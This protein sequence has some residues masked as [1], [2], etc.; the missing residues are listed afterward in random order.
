MVS[1]EDPPVSPVPTPK[2]KPVISSEEI[3]TATSSVE[4]I[5][6]SSPPLEEPPSIPLDQVSSDIPSIGAHLYKNEQSPSTFVPQPPTLEEDTPQAVLP[7]ESPPSPSSP[8]LDPEAFA[9]VKAPAPDV[10]QASPSEVAGDAVAQAHPDPPASP[11]TTSTEVPRMKTEDPEPYSVQPPSG[12]PS[13]EIGDSLLT[14]A[15]L[16]APADDRERSSET[17]YLVS[18]A[19]PDSFPRQAVHNSSPPSYNAIKQFEEDLKKHYQRGNPNCER[20]AVYTFRHPNGLGSQ[21]TLMTLS[22][23]TALLENRAFLLSAWLHSYQC[24]ADAGKTEIR[25]MC[26]GSGR[27]RKGGPKFVYCFFHTNKLV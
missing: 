6:Q 26:S 21:A 20:V 12:T 15:P 25:Y 24:N 11:T 27:G 8:E 7:L 3:P 1:V 9:S 10:V 18:S 19:T 17:A 13:E 2:E 4:D 14:G 22:F 16:P 23:I 5:P